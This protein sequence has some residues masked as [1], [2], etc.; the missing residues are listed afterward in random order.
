MHVDPPELVIRFPAFGLDHLDVSGWIS[1]VQPPPLQRC[2]MSITISRE[3]QRRS[4]IVKHLVECP[5]NTRL[6]DAW[7]PKVEIQVYN[8]IISHVCSVLLKH[9]FRLSAK[10][11]RKKLNV[12]GRI[13]GST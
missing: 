9:W 6:E 13:P 11:L 3:V 12:T 8:L 4:D 1:G 10:R 7:H 2:D 5:F